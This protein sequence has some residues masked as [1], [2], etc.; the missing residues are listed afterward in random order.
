LL[1]VAGA[2]AALCFVKAYGITFS[3]VGRSAPARE[4]QEVPP[5][6]RAGMGLLALSVLGLGL[7]APLVVPYFGRV[8]SGLIGAARIP[9]ARGVWVFPTET[10][11]ALIS[12]PLMAIL[13]LGLVM[14]PLLILAAL[15]GLRG[16]RRVDETAWACGYGYSPLM[17]VTAGGFGRP[18]ST[19]FSPLYTLRHKVRG[20]AGVVASAFRSLVSSVARVEPVWDDLIYSAIARGVRFAGRR[21]QALQTGDI[22]AYC[23]YIVLTLAILLLIV[24]VR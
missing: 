11:S 22:R 21:I 8:A 14:L 16:G 7:G 6:M 9:M 20:P 2:L 5:T 24:T 15:G 3:G 12:T 23:L 18:L 4:A 13:L 17:A 10:S 19:I 1:V